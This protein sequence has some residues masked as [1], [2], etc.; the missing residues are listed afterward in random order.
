[1]PHEIYTTHFVVRFF[2]TDKEY[3]D[4]RCSSSS[5]SSSS[6]VNV[7]NN[8]NNKNGS[9]CAAVVVLL[10]RGGIWCAN[11]GDARAVLCRG[12]IAL[13][14][15]ADHKPDREDEHQRIKDAGGYVKFKRVLGRL[16]VSRAFGD[17][18]YKCPAVGPKSY[19]IAEPEIRFE[20]LTQQDEFLLLAC[21]GLFDVFSSQ[22]AVDFVRQKLSSM[23]RTEQDPQKVVEE[24]IR[25]AIDERRSKD[26]VTAILATFKRHVVQHNT[27]TALEGVGVK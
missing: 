22:E 7:N 18:E 10:I 14:L 26:N 1:M 23:P 3:L 5:S 27:T 17:G 24:L 11:C 15:S 25:T 19:V 21:D 16:A 8:N 6:S 20:N 13:Q 4:Q 9:G 12:G 2:L